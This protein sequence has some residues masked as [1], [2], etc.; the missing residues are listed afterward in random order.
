MQSNICLSTT[1][2][3]EKI[4]KAKFLCFVMNH[5]VTCY[6]HNFLVTTQKAWDLSK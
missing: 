3:N 4:M 2:L 6:L 5:F 1:K